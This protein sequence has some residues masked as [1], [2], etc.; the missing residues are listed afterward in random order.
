MKQ[1]IEQHEYEDTLVMLNSIF[2]QYG[3]RAV[4]LDFRNSYPRMFEE[5]EIQFR[6]LSPDKKLPSLLK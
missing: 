1:E 5:V 3:V 2:E 6:R 4:L